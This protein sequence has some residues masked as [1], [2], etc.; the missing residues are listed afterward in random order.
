MDRLIHFRVEYHLGNAFPVP[1]IH[2]NHSAMVP[3]AMDP[4][5]QNHFPAH[6]F[7]AQLITGMGTAHLSQYIQLRFVRQW[8]TPYIRKI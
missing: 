7:R 1:Q 8:G 3:A 5:G 4:S 2:K 6:I